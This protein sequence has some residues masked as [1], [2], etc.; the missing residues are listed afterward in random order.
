[1]FLNHEITILTYVLHFP[2]LNIKKEIIYHFLSLC[3]HLAGGDPTNKPSSSK[4]VDTY[5]GL[6]KQ[7][8]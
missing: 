7:F 3:F 6:D 4:V 8:F 1:M 5:M 2:M